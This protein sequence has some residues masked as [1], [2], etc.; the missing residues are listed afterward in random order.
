MGAPQ[1]EN[2]TELFATVDSDIVVVMNKP[3][4]SKTFINR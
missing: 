2:K 3:Y 4:S 1:Y